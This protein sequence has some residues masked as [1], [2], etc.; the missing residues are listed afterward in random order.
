MIALIDAD[1]LAFSAACAAQKRAWAVELEGET[2]CVIHKK[3][4]AYELANQLEGSV[5]ECHVLKPEGI[6]RWY[7]DKL[8]KGVLDNC[9]C[10]EYRMYLTPSTTFRNYYEDYKANRTAARPLHLKAIREYMI[11]EWGAEV[12]DN[13]EADDA[14]SIAGWDAWKNLSNLPLLV[15][16]DKDID[17]VPGEH[18]NWRR[19]ERY[20]VTEE[21]A[22]KELFRSML[23]GDTADNIK[24]I[25]GIGPVKAEKILDKSTNWEETVREMYEKENLDF[26]KNYFLLKLLES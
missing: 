2:L 18:L 8:V 12:C 5:D 14:L 16:I 25:K 26:D 15:H 3:K 10:D 22:R 9:G 20:N 6:A 4:E 11:K 17:Q 19:V 24:G 21:E 1:S 7:L 23:V 13:I